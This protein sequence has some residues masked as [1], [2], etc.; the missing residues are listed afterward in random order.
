MELKVLASLKESAEEV[1]PDQPLLQALVVTQAIHESGFGLPSGGSMLAR[2]YNNLFG[3]KALKSRPLDV[4][5]LP[6]WE[7]V[8]GKAVQTRAKFAVFKD[9]EDCFEQHKVM[10]H[11]PRY[12]LVLEADTLEGIFSAIYLSGYAT[13][14]KYPRKLMSI[15]LMYVR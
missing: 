3:I 8:N 4:V 13:D 14:S 2:K 7:E 6:T 12:R 1:Y 10:M 11:W 5:E 15:Y 9:Y